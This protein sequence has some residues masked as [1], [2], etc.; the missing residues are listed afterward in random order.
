MTVVGSCAHACADEGAFGGF[1]DCSDS[2]Q[3]RRGTRSTPKAS[4]SFCRGS[5]VIGRIVAGRFQL[6][7]QAGAGGMGTVYRARDLTDGA[8]VAVK[9]LTGRELREARALRPRGAI[10]A[11][12]DP[13]GD[14]PLHRPRRRR[15]RRALPRHGVARGRGPGD[16][17]RARAAHR[18]RDG[19]AGAPRGRGAGARA[20]ARHR[21]PRHQARE[22]VPARAG[23]RAPQGARLRHRAAHA[24]RAQADR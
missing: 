15:G 8:T 9:I 18:R 2:G 23:D 24:R 14:R 20:R 16:A 6:E 11:G 7:R 10:L 1:D 17:P 5:D 4:R 3:A 21:P 13:P 19:G 22:P 12:L